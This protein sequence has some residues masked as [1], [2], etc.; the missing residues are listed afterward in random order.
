[1]D[2]TDVDALLYGEHLVLAGRNKT[3]LTEDANAGMARAGNSC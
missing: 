3:A 2:A 1:M